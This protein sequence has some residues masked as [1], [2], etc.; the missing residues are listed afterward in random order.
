METSGSKRLLCHH[1]DMKRAVISCVKIST[2]PI[3]PSGFA[4]DVAFIGLDGFGDQEALVSRES[5]QR[6]D[7]HRRRFHGRSRVVPCQVPM[8]VVVGLVGNNS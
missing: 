2:R 6:V 7:D 8:D 3:S 5:V 1:P 4:Q